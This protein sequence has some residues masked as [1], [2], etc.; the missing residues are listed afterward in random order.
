MQY[1]TLGKTGIKVSLASYGTGG[2]SQ[3]GQKAGLEQ[4]AQTSLIRRCLELG[5]NLFDT[6]ERYGSSEEIL[7]RALV[8]VPRDSYHLVTKWQYHNDGVPKDDAEDLARSLEQSLKRLNTDHVDIMMIH[9]IMAADY[10]LVLH[11]YMPVMERLKSEGK[12]RFNGF[13]TRF[14]VDPWQ[15]SPPHALKKNPELWDTIMLKYGIL[16]QT[17]AAEALPL[18]IEHNVGI[19]NMASVRIRLPDPQLLEQTIAEWKDKGY[20]TKDSV[21]AKNPLGWLVHGDVDSVISAAYKFGADH[22]AISTVITGTG[23]MDHLETNIAALE[24]PGL[25]IEDTQ[26]IRELFGHIGEYA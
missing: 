7:G 19:L 17:A 23:S 21:P 12:F 25:P 16:N 5:V 6:H 1:R 11:R 22:P 10:D 9:G 13:S 24:K 3:F 20:M 14:V 8:G 26:R 4:D 15:E 18:A 2:Q